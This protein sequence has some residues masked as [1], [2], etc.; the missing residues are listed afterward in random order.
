MLN[1]ISNYVEFCILFYKD[2]DKASPLLYFLSLMFSK[3]FTLIRTYSGTSE[4]EAG[5][6]PGWDARKQNPHGQ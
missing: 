1:N 4:Y 5:I 6:H 2:K 3:R